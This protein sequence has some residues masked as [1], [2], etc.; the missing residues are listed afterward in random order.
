[1]GHPSRKFLKGENWG[2]NSYKRAQNPQRHKWT[3]Q[4]KQLGTIS[5][6]EH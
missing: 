6:S 3:E 4:M 1:M 2:K 5:S